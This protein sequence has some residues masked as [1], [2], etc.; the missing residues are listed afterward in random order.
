MAELAA[1][2]GRFRPL[3]DADPRLDQVNRAAATLAVTTATIFGPRQQAMVIIL[4]GNPVIDVTI[5]GFVTDECATMFPRQPAGDL[6][7]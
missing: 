5:D 4:L 6:L 3:V 7:R 2:I 1:F